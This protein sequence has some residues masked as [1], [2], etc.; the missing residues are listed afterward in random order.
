MINPPTTLHYV[1]DCSV[2]NHPDFPHYHYEYLKTDEAQILANERL[3]F[4]A[5]LREEFLGRG[6]GDPDVHG[7]PG[8]QL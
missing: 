5:E 4:E 8:E 7:Y 6:A 3:M 2:A 1:E